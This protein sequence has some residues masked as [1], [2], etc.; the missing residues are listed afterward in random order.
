LTRPEP[1]KRREK[2]TTT[3]IV[4]SVSRGRQI[5]AITL[6]KDSE[7]IVRRCAALFRTSGERW[8]YASLE[9]FLRR[10]C[11]GGARRG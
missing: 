5:K 3:F 10:R 8:D 11:Y 9:R 4:L 2:W 7:S 1:Q 6:P